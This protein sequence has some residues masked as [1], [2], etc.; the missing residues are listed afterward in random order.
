MLSGA[1]TPVAST[2]MHLAPA[3]L[4]PAV[5]TARTTA[6]ATSDSRHHALAPGAVRRTQDTETSPA[7]AAAAT[8]AATE[9]AMAAARG[10]AVRAAAATAAAATAV[11]ATAVATAMR[12]SPPAIWKNRGKPSSTGSPSP[13]EVVADGFMGMDPGQAK[14]ETAQTCEGPSPEGWLLGGPYPQGWLAEYN[15]GLK[16]CIQRSRKRLKEAGGTRPDERN[17]SGRTSLTREVWVPNFGFLPY[18]KDAEAAEAARSFGHFSKEGEQLDARPQ[19]APTAPTAPSTRPDR[20][21][22]G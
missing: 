8:A 18:P 14:H 17:H 1:T 20:T 2:A 6:L 7:R 12:Q 21:I 9:V 5:A 16:G 3:T 10:A 13:D 19:L 11:A 15:V 4:A 22:V